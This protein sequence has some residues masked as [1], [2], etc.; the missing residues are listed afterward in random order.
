MLGLL[1]VR[2]NGNTVI[3]E[4]MKTG[5]R[6]TCTYKP[7]GRRV[8]GISRRRCKESFFLCWCRH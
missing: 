3:T 4:W 7:L 8:R 5:G 1:H 6:I 2:R